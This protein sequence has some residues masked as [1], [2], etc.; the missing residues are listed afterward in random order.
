MNKVLGT[1]VFL[2][3]INLTSFE[4]FAQKSKTRRVVTETPS[5]AKTRNESVRFGKI[6][7]FS[8]GNGVLIKWHTRFEQDNLGFDIY[9]LNG[10]SVS[11]VNRTLVEGSYLQSNLNADKGRSYTFFDPKGTFSSVYRIK[12][13][14]IGRINRTSLPFLP[15]YEPNFK[16]VSSYSSAEFQRA[17]QQSNPIV[18]KKNPILPVELAKEVAANSSLADL[19][20]QRWVAAQTGVKIGVKEEGIYRVTKAELQAAGFDTS[21]SNNLWQLYLNGVEQSMIVEANGD[22]IEFY[23]RTIDTIDSDVNMYFLVAGNSNGKRMRN[24]IRRN[25]GGNVIGKTLDFSYQKQDRSLYVT[26]ILNGDKENFYSAIITPTGTSIDFELK[27]VD[28]SAPTAKLDIGLQGLTFVSHNV[29]I[30]ING[31]LIS[32]LGGANRNEFTGQFDVPTSALQNGTNTLELKSLDG[33]SDINLLE[34]FRL[35][36][37]R[38]Y[39]AEN[40]QLSFYT[41]NLRVTNLSKFTSSNVRVFDVTF[42]NAPRP[43]TN[44]SARPD[45]NNVGEFTVR[46][47]SQ[48]TNKMIAVAD[49]SIK[50][51]HS[52]VQNNPSSISDTNTQATMLIVTYKDWM[53]EANTW[54]TYRQNDG[55]NVKV[56]DVEDVYDEFGYGVRSAASL[57]DFLNFA[58]SSWQTT[59]NYVLLMGDASYDPKNYEGS[60]FHSYVP[61]RFVDTLYE[62]TGSDEALAD[63]DDDGLSEVAIGRIPARVASDITKALAKV[64]QFEQNLTNIQDRGSLCA[65]DLPVGYDFTGLCNRVQGELP[66][67]M[68][69]LV[70][71]R[72]DAN[73]KT[74]LINAINEGKYIVNYS[75]H[76]T[77]QSWATTAFFWTDD[78]PQLTNQ[79]DLT[80]FTMLTCLNGYFMRPVNDSLSE[81]LL[82]YENGGAV[83]VWS[84][85]GST[86]PD[87]QEVM[88]RRF[89][90]QLGNNTSMN[91]LGD[92]IRDAKANLVSG[93]DVRRS[94]GLLGDPALK[95][96]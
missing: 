39:E 18:V 17:R 24:A 13:T 47:P 87:I 10:K 1:I 38:F 33:S 59:P 66:A 44:V 94:W 43:I 77:T 11:K 62:E 29:E 92:L 25:I 16:N 60:G 78:V 86:T 93:A 57:R 82:K 21:I 95:V 63:F 89:F 55:F 52:I 37:K 53:T 83:A 79:N 84:S 42:P 96:K 32:T 36:F 4:V 64:T 30:K 34:K 71:N 85:S 72:G 49:T 7:A 51:A 73:A 20:T 45:P 27:G 3:I 48:R 31:N 65:S 46:L 23:G 28:F 22:Y 58:T 5:F 12:N 70:I 9:R 14:S 19:N 67:A 2:V 74:A 81:I 41:N 35:D 56:V 69:T 50:S 40:N 61:I 91:R 6:E 88:A 68:P 26:S 76:G 54:A 8:D 90:D 80:I 75:G 15:R